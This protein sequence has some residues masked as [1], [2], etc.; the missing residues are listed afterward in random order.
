MG[1]RN[2]AVFFCE[3]IILPS[4]KLFKYK[5]KLFKVKKIIILFIALTAAQAVH[6]QQPQ[7][8]QRS[9]IIEELDGKEFYIHLVRHGETLQNIASAY[10]VTAVEISKENPRLTGRVNAGDV[11]KIPKRAPVPTQAERSPQTPAVTPAPKAIETPA[12]TTAK[13]EGLQHTVAARETFFGIARRY[14]ISVVELMAANPDIDALQPGQVL[15]I[16]VK[17]QTQAATRPG[18]PE[19]ITGTETTETKPLEP[20]QQ[21]GTYTVKAGETLFSVSRKF[22][23]TIEELV[24][25]NPVLQDGM[26]TGQVIRVVKDQQHDGNQYFIVQDTTVT[27]TYHKVRRRETLFGLSREYGVSMDVILEYNPQVEIEGL[28]PR[29]VLK[30]PVYE[31]TSKRILREVEPVEPVD[32]PVEPAPEPT[33][34]H[35][36]C[37]P[38]P[39]PE[40]VYNIALMMPFFLDQQDEI[41]ETDSAVTVVP[42]NPNRFYEFMQ[43]YYGAM[44]AIDSLSQGGL[45]AKVFVY[46]VDNSPESVMKVLEKPELSNMDLIIG[47]LYAN[48][49]DRVAHFA[50][51]HQIR[52][53][54]PLSPRS[55]FLLNNPF[56]IK[57]Q[58][59][60]RDQV[61]LIASYIHDFYYDRNIFVV[62]QF[63][64]SETNTLEI[65][66]RTLVEADL[67]EVIYIRDSLDGI[68]SK[69]D[70]ERENVVIGLSTDKVFSMDLI[71]KLND[72][73]SEYNIICFGL[74][75]WEDFALDTDHVVNT[76][77][78]LPATGFIDYHSEHVNRFIRSFRNKY[79]TEPLPNRFAFMAFDVTWY[80]VNAMMKYGVAFDECLPSFR[81]RGLQLPFEFEPHDRHGMENKGLT[82]YRIH[83]FRKVEVWPK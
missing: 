78:H 58:P 80:F 73:R 36:D 21:A 31:I 40:R 70:E 22:D 83:D 20:A 6:S 82:L 15:Q 60:V 9:Q 5:P 28:Q 37:R 54:N 29:Q 26:K 45:N 59:S 46:D 51:E 7:A 48:S 38:L 4:K 65:F 56:A 42:A 8:V 16:P 66:R 23:L 75:E 35:E 77:L 17:E 14:N 12:T 3:F 44:L 19:Q 55:E 25:L 13:T 61:E 11:I 67:H 71:R 74:Q 62:R 76:Q 63:S 49:F 34:I 53:V 1:I 52:I 32:V 50:R 81:Y 39:S 64:F 47:P 2:Q 79:D 57:A 24:T 43:F 30:I 41:I 69:L 72:I 33:F 27:Y 68:I 18:I 10:N